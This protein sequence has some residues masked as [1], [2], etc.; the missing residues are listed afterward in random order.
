[1]AQG[2]F[3]DVSS[4]ARYLKTTYLGSLSRIEIIDEVSEETKIFFDN[5]SKTKTYSDSR[6][7]LLQYFPELKN[8]SIDN[9]IGQDLFSLPIFNDERIKLSWQS[10]PDCNLHLKQ[11]KSF[12]DGITLFNYFNICVDLTKLSIP[13]LPIFAFAYRKDRIADF[14]N[15]Y[16]TKK[17]VAI[18][19]PFKTNKKQ[20][21]Q[22]I[23]DN[24]LKIK[25]KQNY[26]LDSP[27]RKIPKNIQISEEI[28]QLRATGLTFKEIAEQF[29]EKYP[30][31]DR[32]KDESAIRGI[33]TR[34]K[35]Y[36]VSGIIASHLSKF[37][38]RYNK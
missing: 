27:D 14:L 5:Y 25:Q 38:S 35:K 6:G 19:M 16:P 4:E 26:L 20:L 36:L 18:F 34:Y 22:W 9:H 37:I 7:I 1:M 2:F 8:F 28:K 12:T 11:V 29:L 21:H 32:L 24:W 10:I 31:D 30:Q 23:D 17:L 15:E 33:Y 3:Q 13:P